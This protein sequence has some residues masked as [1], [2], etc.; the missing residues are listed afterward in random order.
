VVDTIS[1]PIV[2]STEQEFSIPQCTAP[3]LGSSL[4]YSNSYLKKVS[5]DIGFTAKS[6]APRL[7]QDGHTQPEIGT[8]SAAF[9]HSFFSFA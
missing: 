8:L 6:G 7:W 2:L 3:E 4:S 5:F 1:G 9:T